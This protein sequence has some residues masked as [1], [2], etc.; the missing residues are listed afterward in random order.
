MRNWKPFCEMAA[1]LVAS[2]R[3]DRAEAAA[4]E[5]GVALSRHPGTLRISGP[6]PAP[7]E[8]LQGRWRFQILLRAPDRKAVLA[9]LEAAI[10]DRAAAGVQIAV[11]VDPQDLM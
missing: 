4:G 9:A 8:R 3:R 7:L 1:V 10:P 2:P 5:L 11:D 6:A